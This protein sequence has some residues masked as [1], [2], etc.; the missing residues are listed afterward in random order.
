VTDATKDKGHGNGLESAGCVDGGGLTKIGL[1][2][3][4]DTG[5]D[6]A[7][8]SLFVGEESDTAGGILNLGKVHFGCEGDGSVKSMTGASEESAGGF[9]GKS[10]HPTCKT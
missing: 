9:D 7:V 10:A 3:G 4:H 6:F 2:V 5:I 1:E 8:A